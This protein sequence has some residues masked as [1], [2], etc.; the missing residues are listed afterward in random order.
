MHLSD[1]SGRSD[2]SVLKWNARVLRTGSAKNGPS[3]G[4]EP[5]SSLAPVGQ[6]AGIWRVVAEKMYARAR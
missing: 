4:S 5:L 3:H 2:E 6:N 1:K